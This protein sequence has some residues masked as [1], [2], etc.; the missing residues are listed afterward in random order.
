MEII[1]SIKDKIRQLLIE[2]DGDVEA[3]DLKDIIDDAKKIGVE[4]NEV[5][6][7]AADIDASMNWEAIRAEKVK[8][9]ERIKKLK[10]E[11][12][13]QE[14]R[15]QSAPEFI[16]ALVQYC[17]ADGVVEKGEL[18]IIFRKSDELKQDGN[19]LARKLKSILDKGNYK[20]LPNPNLEA[21]TLRDTLLST[22]WY[23]EDK[24]NEAIIALQTKA[25]S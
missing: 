15:L 6:K 24:Y 13:K 5:L 3:H 11:V 2:K 16:D 20:P 17:F 23:N 18:E 22:S 19:V 21:D 10:E 9:I 12:K 1:D 4:K 7:I 25:N 8:E 14:D